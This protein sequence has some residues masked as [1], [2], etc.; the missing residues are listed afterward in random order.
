M[1][2]LISA[3]QADTLT[4]ATSGGHATSIQEA[5]EMAA[6][7]DTIQ[8]AAGTWSESLR[9]TKDLT[10]VSDE[11]SENTSIDG[12]GDTSF[13]VIVEGAKVTLEGFAIENGDGSGVWV[14]DYAELTGVDL[15]FSGLGDD[16]DGG[17]YFPDDYGGAVLVYGA[18]AWLED[19]SFVGGR[20][21]EGGHIAAF[22]SDLDVVDSSFE[23]SDAVNGGAI[24][25]TSTDVRIE[26]STFYDNNVDT[27]GGALYLDGCVLAVVDSDFEDN[28]VYSGYGA[29]A[30]LN[31]SPAEITGSTFTENSATYGYGGALYLG[32]GNTATIRDSEFVGNQAYRSGGAIYTYYTYAEL[33]V[34]DTLFDDNYARYGYGGAIYGY[35]GAYMNFERVDF[36]RNRAGYH[37]G[38]LYNYYYGSADMSDVL[39][40]DNEVDYYSGGG[41][42]L[43]YLWTGYG[44]RLENVRFEGNDALIEGGG[45]FA[46]YLGSL[47]IIDSEF[48]SNGGEPGL[49]GGGLF[50]SYVDTLS[51]HN[52]TFANNHATYGGGVYESLGSTSSKWTNNVLQENSA[53]IGGAACFVDS[54]PTTFTNNGVVGNVAT[55]AASALC[56]FEARHEF[57][58]NLF[59]WNTG[60]SAVVGYDLNSGFYSSFLYNNWWEHP[61]GHVGEEL[62]DQDW[63]GEGS[64]EVDPALVAF[65]ADGDP[66]NDSYVLTESSALIDAGD[67]NIWDP[68][69]SRSDIGPYGGPAVS[70]EDNDG[71]GFAWWLDCNDDDG[72]VHPGA[73]DE[74]YDGVDSDC[75]GTDDMDADGDGV[76]AEE[77]CDDDDASLF[78]DCVPDEETPVDGQDT[79]DPYDPG[80]CSTVP[81]GGAWL[82]AL[83]ALRRRRETPR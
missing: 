81:L 14:R 21:Q 37:G 3:A 4:V 82:L 33:D 11:G 23:G 68:D 27:S 28:S 79:R 19:C 29:A 9:I 76:S 47:E 25:A 7:G 32:S 71:D 22:A 52:S 62:V 12:A 43:Y 75:D 53:R 83:V 61:D 41:A 56:M 17:D 8:V 55:D 66:D 63:F 58:N 30:Y 80:G 36:T 59:A 67:P 24:Y 72:A 51:V 38:A 54:A 64:L 45:L 57:T 42:Y 77:D 15:V 13:A 78:E 20:A 69:E 16:L 5:V 70:A 6:P 31:A 2:L 48:V 73:D 40:S 49:Y 44:A 10:I 65:T 39:F 34:A 1:L 26:R 60:A 74:W 46:R 18:T 50:A 35:V